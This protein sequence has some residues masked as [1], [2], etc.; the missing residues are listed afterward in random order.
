MKCSHNLHCDKNAS[1][2]EQAEKWILAVV[3]DDQVLTIW[4][5]LDMDF[6]HRTEVRC[7]LSSLK[8]L[9]H[10]SS[11]Y[12]HCSILVHNNITSTVFHVFLTAF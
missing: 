6:G 4:H 5:F 9:L 11:C 1:N 12:E 10:F 7:R 2:D 3:G 8:F